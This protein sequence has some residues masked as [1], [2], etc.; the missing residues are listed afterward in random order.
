MM[1]LCKRCEKSRAAVS[2]AF[3]LGGGLVIA[4][5]ANRWAFG[6][7]MALDA[8]IKQQKEKKAAHLPDLINAEDSVPG[9]IG[10]FRK[11]NVPA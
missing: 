2:G 9:T 6:K 4:W 10:R 7:P 1:P 11:R 3:S 8:A 5:P